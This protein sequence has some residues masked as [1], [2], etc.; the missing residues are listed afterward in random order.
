MS[1]EILTF[2]ANFGLQESIKYLT[3]IFE[4]DSGKEKRRSKWAAP[5][6]TLD[7]SLNNEN[8]TDIDAI[9]DFYVAR[10]GRYDT[11]WVKFPTT[12]NKVVVGEAVGTGAG[13]EQVFNLDRFPVDTASVK[14]YVGG[15]LLTSGYTVSNDLTA[16][17]SKITFTAPP[18]GVITADYE[19][20]IQVR[21]TED[22]LT[23]ELIS[24][25]LYNASISLTEVLWDIYQAP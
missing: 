1:T 8:E 10:K 21:F 11:F 13:V 2:N 4:A 22:T 16:E 20:Y 5:I 19:F 6:R 23:R 9:W 3:N 15:V 25:K 14:V 7:F 17:V 18:M 12:K 24:V